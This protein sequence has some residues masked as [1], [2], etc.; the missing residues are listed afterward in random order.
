MEDIE[1][2]LIA[3]G[4][5]SLIKEFKMHYYTGPKK[6]PLEI[7]NKMIIHTKM[8]NR[9]IIIFPGYNCSLFA[10]GQTGSGKSYSMVGYGPNK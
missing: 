6:K 4:F 1:C 3:Y 10:Y 5:I 8:I 2:N 9:H 7:L